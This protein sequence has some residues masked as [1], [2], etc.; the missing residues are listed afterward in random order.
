MFGYLGR[1]YEGDAAQLITPVFLRRQK[2]DAW[3]DMLELKAVRA[4]AWS[5]TH[6]SM[7]RQ[8]EPESRHHTQT[9]M[10]D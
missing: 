8:A 1:S 5:C 9:A 10:V 7:Q 3:F 2:P 4:G 6:K